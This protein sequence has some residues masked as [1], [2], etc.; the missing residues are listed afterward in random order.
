MNPE[1][2]TYTW[3]T[4][5]QDSIIVRATAEVGDWFLD[6]RRTSERTWNARAS[7]GLSNTDAYGFVSLAEAQVWAESQV[8]A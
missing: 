8:P 4:T 7:H 6:L 3:Q 1:P 5:K 2:L